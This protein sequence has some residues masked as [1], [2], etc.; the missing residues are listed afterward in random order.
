[1]A[2]LRVMSLGSVRPQSAANKQLGILSS[3]SLLS[4]LLGGAFGNFFVFFYI[5]HYS[6]LSPSLE[7]GR[8]NALATTVHSRDLPCKSQS[9]RADMGP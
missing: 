5:F 8:H 4:A 7:A 3:R 9:D 1:M 6:P 2:F